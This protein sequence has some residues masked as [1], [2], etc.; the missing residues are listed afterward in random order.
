MTI[1]VNQLTIRNHVIFGLVMRRKNLAKKC[2]ERIL[3]KQIREIEYIEPEKTEEVSADVHGIRLD[4]YFENEETVYNVELQAYRVDDLPKRSRYY[5][6]MMDMILLEKGETYSALKKNIVIFI[7]TFDPFEQERHLYSFENRC[8]QD[9]E[10]RREDESM[11]VFL[12]TKG[13]M[14]DIPRPLRLFLDYIETGEA[15]DEYTKEL[16]QAVV[17]VR[18]DDKWREPIMTWEMLKNDVA[19]EARKEGLEEGRAEGREEGLAEGRTEG[20]AEGELIGASKE[21]TETVL[22]MQ[23]AGKSLEDILI[24]TGMTEE[25]VKSITNPE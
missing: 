19:Y 8:V 24:A 7:C 6:D 13:T 10:I 17:E 12:N 4:V 5:Q 23:K 16:H 25:E 20:L 1:D 11:K 22:R 14:D 18:T 21:K 9:P 3:G 2:I 15:G